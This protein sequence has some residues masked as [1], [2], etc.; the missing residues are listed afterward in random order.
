MFILLVQTSLCILRILID[1]NFLQM[2][3]IVTSVN[4]TDLGVKISL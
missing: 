2:C 1:F 3:I 4:N